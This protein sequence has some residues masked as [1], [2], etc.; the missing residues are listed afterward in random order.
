[1]NKLTWKCKTVIH[2]ENGKIL[3]LSILKTNKIKCL[4]IDALSCGGEQHC[5][6]LSFLLKVYSCKYNGDR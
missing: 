2:V 5:H 4:L 1:M 3:K 6:V